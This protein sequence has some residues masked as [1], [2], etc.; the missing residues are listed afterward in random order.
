MPP[1]SPPFRASSWAELLLKRYL[2][3]AFLGNY[4]IFTVSMALLMAFH[5]PKPSLQTA[6]IVLTN[7][8]FWIPLIC[9][10]PTLP[11]LITKYLWK[12]VLGD[13]YLS[14]AWEFACSWSLLIAGVVL[15]AF[16]VIV[17]IGFWLGTTQDPAGMGQS[18]IPMLI[19]VIAPTYLIISA[20]GTLIGGTI[21][22]FYR[23]DPSQ[24]QLIGAIVVFMIYFAGA[25]IYF[26]KYMF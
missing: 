8:L 10:V 18:M 9:F 3:Y 20:I 7:I 11:F 22:A 23:R 26:G 14:P 15:L 24:L 25:L 6:Y 13:L 5:P 17:A 16:N 1:Q 4:L 19:I 12:I 21:G 2:A